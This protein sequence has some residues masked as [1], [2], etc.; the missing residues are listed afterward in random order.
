[1]KFN[2][3]MVLIGRWNQ[4]KIIRKLTRKLSILVLPSKWRQDCRCSKLSSWR[5]CV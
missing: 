3:D 1:M 2:V 5:W 4:V